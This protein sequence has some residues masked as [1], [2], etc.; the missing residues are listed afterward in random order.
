[1]RPLDPEQAQAVRGIVA[2]VLAEL[3]PAALAQRFGNRPAAGGTEAL[4]ARKLAE[5]GE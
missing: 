5:A 2:E 3:L 1:M 4:L